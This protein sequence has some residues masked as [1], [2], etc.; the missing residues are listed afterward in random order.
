MAIYMWIDV[1]PDLC[2][3]A[4]TAGSTV[5]LTVWY[6]TPTSVTLE[7]ST[8]GKIW[9]SYSINDTITL[10][11][12]WDKVY[13]RNTSTTT[14]WFSTSWGNYYKFVMTW[15]IAAS[16]DV[17]SLVNKNGTDTISQY[18]FIQLFEN[19]SALTTP[20][21]LSWPTSVPYHWYY[22]MFYNCTNL[23]ALPKLPATSIGDRGYMNMFVS[24]SKIKLS[25]T[26]TWDYQ[27]AYRL[28]SEW[29]WSWWSLWSG[30][31]FW[32]TW[33]TFTWSPSINTTY[34]TSNTVV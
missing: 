10:S 22:W 29:T 17:T 16:G 7:T 34:Y 12:V 33:W 24:C 9:T 11:N 28:P 1:P 13:F 14:T 27:T 3:T 32:K 6:W 2:F 23:E 19:C 26:Q 21:S 15:S 25:T 18:N 5:K 4:N 31:M 30:D 8:N 20:P